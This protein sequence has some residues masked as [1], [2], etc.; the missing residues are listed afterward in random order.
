MTMT[1]DYDNELMLIADR[2]IMFDL[3]TFLTL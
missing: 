1:I 2:R 3:G